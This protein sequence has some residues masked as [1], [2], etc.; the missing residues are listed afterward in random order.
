MVQLEAMACAKPVISTDLA[1][2][3]PWVNRH[4]ETGLVVPPGDPG[5]LREA[6]DR[7][8]GD[9]ALRDRFGGAGR[10]RVTTE[11]TLDRMVERTVALYRAVLA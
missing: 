7:L 6:L 10:R 2:G 3:V 1:T 4:E 8:L 5:A 11:F 9:E